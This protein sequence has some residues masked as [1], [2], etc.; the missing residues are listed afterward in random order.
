MAIET[1]MAVFSGV[2]AASTVAYAILTWKLFSETQKMR[3]AQTEPRVSI[4]LEMD[5]TGLHGYE[6]VI[7]NE[8]EGVARNVRFEFEGD[9]SYF[10]ESF[11]RGV[12]PTVDQ[13]PIITDGLPYLEPGQTFRFSL[14]T[15][16]EK[17]FNRAAGDPWIFRVQ[18]E[19][20]FGEQ[21]KD[22]YPLDFSQFRGMFFAPNRLVEISQHLDSI[23]KDLN[24]VS[25]GDAKIQV[26]IQKEEHCQGE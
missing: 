25:E 9:S 24:R 4:R 21:R 20:L 10:R 8:G 17:E 13:L 19:N 15:V 2:V 22:T 6:L 26:V 12:L 14:G 11:I 18:Y 1:W 16:S 7:R 5:H 3:E 23:R